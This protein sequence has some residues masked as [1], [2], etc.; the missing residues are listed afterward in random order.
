MWKHG[1]SLVLLILIGSPA[2]AQTQC[3]EFSRLR[4]EAVAA[5]KPTRGAPALGRCDSYTRI[6]IAWHDV[7]QYA[8]DHRDA[9]DIP[10]TTLNDIEK[11]HREAVKARD[12]VCT[13][14]PVRPYP[15][16]IILH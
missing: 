9:C 13:G 4:A 7:A 11:L 15:A 6:S 14:R 2:I 16:D 8:S 12:N 10:L 3:P 1:T 5:A